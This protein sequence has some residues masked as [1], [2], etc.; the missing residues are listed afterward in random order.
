MHGVAFMALFTA[1]QVNTRKLT[2]V[3]CKLD[4]TWL[5]LQTS[6]SFQTTVLK[7]QN[8]GD[9]LGFQSLAIIYAVFSVCNFI[10]PPI[11]KSLGPRISMFAVLVD[12][13]ISACNRVDCKLLGCRIVRFIHCHFPQAGEMEYLGCECLGGIGGSRLVDCTR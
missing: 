8:L 10:A 4:Q 11:V 7:D 12:C 5:C 6:G 13:A 1:F 2:D 9:S 3:I